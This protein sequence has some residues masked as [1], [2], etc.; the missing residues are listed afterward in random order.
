[1][2]P[3]HPSVRDVLQRVL[4]LARQLDWSDSAAVFEL[5]NGKLVAN[6]FRSPHHNVLSS[7]SASGLGAQEPLVARALA[8]GVP[9][10]REREVG[11]LFTDESTALAIPIQDYA[12]LYLGR[13]SDEPFSERTET[14]LVAL[15]QQAHFALMVARM[16]GSRKV[17]EKEEADSRKVAES[18]LDSVSSIVEIM[19]ELLALKE[20]QLVLQCAGDNLDKIADFEFWAIV[21]GEFGENDR[22]P[23]FL[24]NTRKNDPID[25]EA[26]LNLSRVGIRAGRTLS[27]SNM[28]R[29]TLPQPSPNLSSA[30]IC[31]MLAD[32]QVIGCLTLGSVR[33][34]FSRHERELLSTL[35]LQVGSHFWNL[36]LHH[37]LAETHEALKHSQAQLIQ[38]SKMAAVGQ[39]AA[40]VAHEL[41]TPLGAMNLAIEGALRVLDNKPE[42]AGSRLERALKS[43]NQLKEIVSKLL[44]YS[45]PTDAEGQETYLHAVVTDALDLLG[46][47]LRLDSVEIEAV[48]DEV[49]PIVANHNELQQVVINLL[50]NARDAILGRSPERPLIEARTFFCTDGTVA[51]SVKDNGTGMDEKTRDR[52]FEPFFTTKDVGKGTGLGLSVTKEIVDRNGGRIEVDTTPGDGTTIILKFK[53]PSEV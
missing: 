17:L 33:P 20:P 13:R 53:K 6:V 30:L 5:E 28:Q 26:V 40:G 48:L 8:E 22:P 43:G 49:P 14:D 2:M 42:R 34:C 44:H 10:R 45:K 7:A 1:M 3:H 50:T 29:L 37:E 11:T 27:F 39:L 18:L 16:S 51:L 47:Q 38:S 35:A 24:A 31:P 23:Y 4:W 52:V 12:V 15:C 21:A 46:H 19:G 9:Q 41:N 25:R 36:H 32:G